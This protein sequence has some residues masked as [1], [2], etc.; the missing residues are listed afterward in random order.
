MMNPVIRVMVLAAALTAAA[1]AGLGLDEGAATV[2]GRAIYPLQ[3][4]LPPNSVLRVQL[5]DVSRQDTRAVLLSET[6]I[7]LEGR[8]PPIAF[9]LAYRRE[10][11][12]PSHT[13]SVRAALSVGERLLFTTTESYPVVTR[14][15]PTD[16]SIR[17]Q[18]VRPKSE[19]GRPSSKFQ[20]PG[21]TSSS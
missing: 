15:A 14:G 16:V 3:P 17:L 8:Q 1:C 21:S 20:V 12:K 19:G 4:P 11:I 10:A 6:T 18:P 7:P 5:L 2:T 9:S 13:Y